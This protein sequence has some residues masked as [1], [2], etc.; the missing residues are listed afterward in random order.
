MKQ[1]LILLICAAAPLMGSSDR[2]VL[3]FWFK[4]ES[5]K[6]QAMWWNKSA[7]VDNEVEALFKEDLVRAERGEYDSW[8]ETPEGTLALIILLDQFP[9][10]IFRDQ[11]TA[12]AFDSK[13]QQV[14]LEGIRQGFDRQLTGF[15]PLFFYMPLMHSEEFHI[16]EISVLLYDLLRKT[17]SQFNSAYNFAVRHRDIIARFGRFP[18]RNQALGRESTEEELQFLKEPGSSF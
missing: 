4:G 3:N 15:M 16:Q 2:D 12:F 11:G 13:A 7:A 14:T 6:S 10:H 17:K 5:E 8:M 1:L 9:R 18:H